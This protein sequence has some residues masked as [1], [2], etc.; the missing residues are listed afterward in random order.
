MQNATQNATIVVLSHIAGKLKEKQRVKIG[1]VACR[2][3]P[4]EER[5]YRCW[6]AGH[7]SNNFKGVD[8]TKLCGDCGVEGHRVKSQKS[9]R[10]P[11]LKR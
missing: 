1:W 4:C 2:V 11:K 8:C 9:Q 7:I 3:V 5:C 6:E 10:C